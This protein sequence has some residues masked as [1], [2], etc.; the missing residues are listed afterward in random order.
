MLA[1]LARRLSFV[2]FVC[3]VACLLGTGS[4][5][6][7]SGAACTGRPAEDAALPGCGLQVPVGDTFFTWRREA[8][9]LDQA[10]DA[11][12]VAVAEDQAAAF[13]EMSV[14][15][16]DA[17][18][19]WVGWSASWPEAHRTLHELAPGRTYVI[20]SPAA[21]AWTFGD[22]TP[23]LQR[24]RIVSYYGHPGQP[25]MGILGEYTPEEA[26]RRVTAMAEEFTHLDPQR[27][28]VPALHLIVAVA[29]RYPGKSGLYLGHL[30]QP[31]LD[32]YVRATAEG[33][34]LL[35]L[36]IQVGWSDPLTEVEGYEETLLDDHVQVALDPEYATRSEDAAPGRAVGSLD[37][38]EIN[39]VQAYLDALVDEHHLQRKILIVHQ[40]RDDMILRPERLKTYPNV[41]LVI[42]MDGFG[43]RQTKLWGY[44]RFAESKASAYPAIKLFFKWDIKMFSPEELLG[45]DEPPA[46]VI[47][48]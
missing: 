7:A 4:A 39:A 30:S 43:P 2:L 40:F 25:A 47:Y 44:G 22:Q 12:R 9:P 45:F 31:V 19:T 27:P 42:D 33:G 14:W 3:S 38:D 46:I 13:A 8:L 6:A 15:G 1:V 21:F 48:Q 24:A 5:S 41:D 20:A 23:L 10:F 34:A 36:D 16:Q 11:G 37:A 32:D 26:V 18:G 29:Q 35:F 28:A 17:A